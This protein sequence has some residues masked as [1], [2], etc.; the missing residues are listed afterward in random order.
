[1]KQDPIVLGAVQ[2]QNKKLVPTLK[3]LQTLPFAPPFTE[4][5][6]PVVSCLHREETKAYSAPKT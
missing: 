5:Q 1:M 2:T 6:K 3:I 4:A